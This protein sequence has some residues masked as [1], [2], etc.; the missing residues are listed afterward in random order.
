MVKRPALSTLLCLTLMEFSLGQTLSHSGKGFDYESA[1]AP[2]R[3]TLARSIAGKPDTNILDACYQIA[4]IFNIRSR[5]S[6]DSHDT[7]YIDSSQQYV[8]RLIDDSRQLDRPDYEAAA[9]TLWGQN[10]ISSHADEKAI[11]EK[12]LNAL[13]LCD[14][15]LRVHHTPNDQILERQ[16]IA[17]ANIGYTYFA[18]NEYQN[19]LRYCDSA[20]RHAWPAYAAGL[21]L[22]YKARTYMALNKLTDA[23]AALRK[24]LLVMSVQPMTMRWEAM[25]YLAG[26]YIRKGEPD[27]ALATIRQALIGDKRGYH[28]NYHYY[29]LGKAYLALHHRNSAMKYAQLEL[30]LGT[31]RGSSTDRLRAFELL[32]KID[33][34]NN[35]TTAELT[36]FRQWVILDDSL[37]EAQH[38]KD[39]AEVQH[40]Y[41]YQ[42][43]QEKAEREHFVQ[44]ERLHQ[45]TRW[46]LIIVLFLVALTAALLAWYNRKVRRKN[47]ELAKKNQE[48]LDAHFKGQHF[49]RKRVASELHDNLSSL[50]A[51][52]KLSIQVLDPSA[53]PPGE[54]KL[55]QSVLDM[56]DTAC[57]EVRYIAHNMMPVNL[58]RQGL[59]AALESL[60]TKLN[61]TGIIAFELTNIDPRLTLDKVTAF[62][63]YSICLECCNNIL[64]H[65]RATRAAILFKATDKEL[66]LLI[67][68]NGKGIPDTR[69]DGMGIRN[70]NERIESLRGSLEIQTSTDGTSFWFTIPLTPQEVAAR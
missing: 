21:P 5:T 4:D 39:I 35:S 44:Q 40:K 29:W 70:V 27:S 55:F 66:H 65:S 8:L 32:Y 41:D 20:V 43:V 16:S 46:F 15:W 12:F 19:A 26:L 11:V 22:V 23:E 10:L 61:Q 17:Y 53:L 56:M 49:E 28:I 13:T 18:N 45:Q 9:Y 63:I 34:L 54:Q 48:I 14:T 24:A 25:D 7:T 67:S 3:Q 57:N 58:E 31:Q 33:S 37:N 38:G 64:R 36:H 52:T 68:D 69:K 60:V 2:L 42:A 62:N 59:P 1:L 50:L 6:G 30:A 51:A 47:T